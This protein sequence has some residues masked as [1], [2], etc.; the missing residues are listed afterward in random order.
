MASTSVTTIGGVMVITQVIPRDVSSIPLQTPGD[1]QQQAPPPEVIAPPT[2]SKVVDETDTD[3]RRE[4]QG[5]GVVQ[6]FVGLLSVL[7]SLTP[8][9]SP[10][11][12]HYAP[13]GSGLFFVVSGSLAVASGR[14]ASVRLVWASLLTN[15][16]SALLGLAGVVYDCVLLSTVPSDMFC[17]SPSQTRPL[18]H[19]EWTRKCFRNLWALNSVLYGILG[20]VL[21]LLVLQVCVCITVCVLAGRAIRRHKCPLT[22]CS[23][24][25]PILSVQITQSRVL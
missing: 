10:V 1:P 17:K 2:H 3:V 4:P 21:V 22:G 24:P 23:Q 16:F 19:D 8:L 25:I 18:L 7:F 5:L 9:L 11:L 6:I 13:F 15:A 20:V 12:I 14:R